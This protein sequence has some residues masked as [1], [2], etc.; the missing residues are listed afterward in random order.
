MKF[1]PDSSGGYQSSFLIESS[2]PQN[3]ISTFLA[4]GSGIYAPAIT[5]SDSILHKEMTVTDSAERV[6]QIINQGFGE[7]YFNAQI[8]GYNPGGGL[9][10]TGGSDNF[11]HIWI[12]SNEPSG[13]AFTWVDI[14]ASGTALSFSG[15]SGISNPVT[16][17]FPFSFYG[18][19]YSSLRICTNGWMSF[20]TYSVSYNNV[21]LPSLLAP[22][23]LIAPFWDYLNYT[24]DSRIYVEN[25]DQNL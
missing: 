14:S 21:A 24:S 7:L 8:A 2:D 18:Q 4:T 19:T 20:T 5:A 23:A 1:T 15:S 11:G 9:E 3:F 6:I 10:G 25:Q 13:P 16:I 12:D 22:R 17:G